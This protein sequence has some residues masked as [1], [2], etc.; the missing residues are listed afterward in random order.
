MA[1]PTNYTPQQIRDAIL[2]IWRDPIALG[3]AI[4]YCGAAETR[5]SLVAPQDTAECAGAAALRPEVV[6]SIGRRAAPKGFQRKRFGTFHRQMLAHV[7]SQ[8]KTSTIVPRGHAK[9]TLITVIDTIHHLLHY[10]ESRNL[11]ACATLDLARKLVGEI[12]DRLNGPLEL[13]PGLYI[14]FREAFPWLAINGD[15]KKSG[16]VDS[17]NI[18][19]RAGKGREPSVFAAS[20]ESNLAG[21][22]PTRAVIDDPSNE[23]NSRTFARRRKVID[24]IEA[25]EPLMFSPDSPINHIGTPWAFQ[26]VTA[27]LERRED[28]SQ[29]RFGVWDGFNPETSKADGK[30]PGPDGAWPLCP[31]FLDADEIMEKEASLTKTFFAAQ[32]KTHPIPAEEAV[33][34][35]ALLKA[36]T[37]DDLALAKLPDDV[38]K[39]LLYDPV[40]RLENTSGDLNGIVILKVIPAKRLGLRGF[41]PDRNIF[42]PIEAVELPGGADSAVNWIE[43]SAA[44]RHA[45][46]LQSLWVENVAAQ[47]LFKPWLEERGKL[48][49]LRIRGQKVGNASL[50][51]RLMGLQTAMRKGYLRLPPE[52]PGRE[53][54]IQ[55]LLEYPLSDSD[56]MISALAL[57]STQADRLGPL[58]GMDPLPDERDTPETLWTPQLG[59]STNGNDWPS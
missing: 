18:L 16:P 40:A 25:L 39:L 34:E 15:L 6:P 10:P 58:P 23:Q 11:I 48:N 41:E 17:F 38:P 8:A 45:P 20:V 27:F 29:F 19:G 50:T 14:P 32:Y 31:S 33:F 13:L 59:G 26:D 54:L 36:A 4:G 57:L 35:P 49:G 1:T 37:D 53:L 22:H 7:R 21:N 55:R 43:D 5:S 46:H 2:L 3:E 9:S 24:F 52:F 47:S 12:R 42:V 56:D 30:G 44:V 51:F 28:W